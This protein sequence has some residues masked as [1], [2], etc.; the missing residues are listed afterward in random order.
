MPALE[1]SRWGNFVSVI[2]KAKLA[3]ELSENR[4][5]DYELSRYACYLIAQNAD[6]RKKVVAFGQNHFAIQ[7]R[8]QSKFLDIIIVIFY[9]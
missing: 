5:D 1:Y 7:T 9:T 6:S 2:N 8:K 4:I 3:C